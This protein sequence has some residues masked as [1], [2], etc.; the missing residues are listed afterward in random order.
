MSDYI[1]CEG[2]NTNYVDTGCGETEEH[3]RCPVVCSMD[4]E[5]ITG[6]E[7]GCQGHTMEEYKLWLAQ[8]M[9][10]NV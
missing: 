8:I 9:S 7:D 2:C 10:R 4:G 3:A 6:R 5:L 1:Y